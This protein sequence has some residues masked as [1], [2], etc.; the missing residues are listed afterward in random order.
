MGKTSKVEREIRGLTLGAMAFGALVA[1]LLT[2]A[3]VGCG[4]LFGAD[5]S[6]GEGGETG[7]PIWTAAS[8][9]VDAVSGVLPPQ[10]QWA[11]AGLALLFRKVRDGVGGAGKRLVDGK[12]IAAVKSLAT[13]PGIVHSADVDKPGLEG[14][15]K[16][17][18]EG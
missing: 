12:P 15:F 18:K 1:V 6:A 4:T 7:S 17:P 11:W 14:I 3:L 2:G 8:D 9:A 10:Y 16:A 13:I 5:A